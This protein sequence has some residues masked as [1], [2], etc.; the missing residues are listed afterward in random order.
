MQSKINQHLEQW[1]AGRESRSSEYFGLVFGGAVVTILVIRAFLAITNYPQLGSD[2]LHIAHMLWGGLFLLVAMIIVLYFHGHRAKIIGS[3]LSGI[4]FGFFIDE[5]GKFITADN[6]YFYQPT[7]MIIYIIFVLLWATLNW[8]DSYA[9]ITKRQK[10]IDMLTRLRDA[11]ING[12]TK[13]D[14]VLISQY[15]KELNI[16]DS[17]LKSMLVLSKTYS[18]KYNKS[19]AQKYIHNIVNSIYKY[20]NKIL[21]NNYT[22]YLFIFISV[23]YALLCVLLIAGQLD[24]IFGLNINNVTSVP[25]IISL[26]IVI[27]SAVSFVMLVYGVIVSFKNYNYLLLWLKRALLV[28]IFITQVFLFYTNQ[29][30]AAFGLAMAVLLLFCVN[31]ILNN[32]R[33]NL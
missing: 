19:K 7:P 15:A 18:P 31:I 28:N 8:L 32:S 4:G 3:V 5:L 10:Y 11:S 33:V 16:G 24:N 6:D 30:T 14:K 9:P 1:R 13:S 26:G 23:V 17:Q 29:F 27:S 20:I 22:K 12:M 2:S 21:D 25:I